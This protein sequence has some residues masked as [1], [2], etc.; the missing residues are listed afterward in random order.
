MSFSPSFKTPD[1]I[2]LTTIGPDGKEIQLY[3]YP[4]GPEPC[5]G[6]EPLNSTVEYRPGFAQVTVTLNDGIGVVGDYGAMLWQVG[7]GDLNIA[8]GCNL[9]GCADCYW[10]QCAME[11]QCNNLYTGVGKVA[12]GFDLPG[13]MLPF[14]CTE[15]SGWVVAKGCF[16]CGTPNLCVSARFK[17]CTPYL[18]CLCLMGEGGF[19]THVY[20]PRSATDK[21]NVFYAGGYGAITL[22]EVPEGMSL[23]VNNGLFFCGKDDIAFNVALP[24]DCNSCLF[25]GEGLVVK[26]DGPVKIYTQNRDERV[27]MKL[28]HPAP[29]GGQGGGAEA[30]AGGGE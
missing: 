20:L 3:N 29:Q 11:A 7:E 16:I 27:F 22:Q 25:G 1:P 4:E 5:R 10:R 21:D 19:Q 24:G 9:G 13:D 12:F 17:G 6:K 28:L 18:P 2:S 23:Y 26:F 14:S 8:T 15:Q 30:A